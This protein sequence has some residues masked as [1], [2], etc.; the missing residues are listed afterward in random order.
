MR[1]LIL[2]ISLASPLFAHHGQDFL[3]TLDAA[4]LASGEFL[5]L[6]RT[7]F[8]SYQS[9]EEFGVS[10]SLLAGLPGDLSIGATF[11]LTNNAEDFSDNALA[12]SPSIQWSPEFSRIGSLSFSLSGAWEF[13]LREQDSHHH[14]H[15]EEIPV[16]DCSALIG[17]PHLYQACLAANENRQNHTHDESHDHGGIHRH[18]QS[19]GTLRLIADWDATDHFKIAGNL[20]A[21][22]PEGDSPAFGYALAMRQEVTSWLALGLE[23]TGDFD[24]GGE[25]LALATATFR[26]TH[27]H[28]LLIGAGTGLG[29]E[30]A[31]LS[32][33][34]SFNW[35]F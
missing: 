23:G 25:H 9:E 29:D 8:T 28:T 15:G 18:G 33:H 3:V 26:P 4:P 27:H 13:A 6:T 14:D 7:E 34:T 11:L 20:I 32:L 1:K 10:Q 31:E 17:I 21:V 35:R 24:S 12:L 2:P 19:H 5:S 16:D 30:S 22:F